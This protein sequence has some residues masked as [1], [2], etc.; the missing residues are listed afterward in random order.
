MI[1]Q[2]NAPQLPRGSIG[3]GLGIAGMLVSLYY[4][5]MFISGNATGIELVIGVIFALTLDYGKVA[6]ATEALYALASFR[7]ISA[8]VYSLIVISLYCLSM[9]AAT[10]IL[11]S[12]NTSAIADQA[13][14]KV[15]TIQQDITAKRAELSKCP[16]GIMTKCINPR[17]AEL[18]ALQ[19]ELATAQNISGDVIAAKNTAATWQKLAKTL[20]ST[21]DE[22]Q[23]KL[24]FARAILLEIIAPIFVSIFLSAYR[25]RLPTAT[26]QIIQ[27]VNDAPVWTHA[28]TARATIAAHAEA[29]AEPTQPIQQ[30]HP[31]QQ[32]TAYKVTGLK[33]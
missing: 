30:P 25:N 5:I 29:K 28:D 6:L 31:V 13:D 21:P 2:S 33:L 4:S 15:I 19:A 8:V 20:G 32:P 27:P 16:A 3:F 18:Q 22:L 17:T 11:T 10:F 23:V 9:L 14:Q 24:A 7:L 12:H 26:P 1:I